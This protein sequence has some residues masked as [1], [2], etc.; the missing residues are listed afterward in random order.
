MRASQQTLLLIA[1]FEGFSPRPYRCPAGL[2]TIGYGHVIGAGEA[3][4]AISESQGIQWLRR[5]VAQA[6]MAVARLITVPLRQHQ[7]DALV[8]FTFNLGAGALQ[9]SA[10]RRVVNR[11]AHDE[12]PAQLLRWV[13]GGGKKLPGLVRRRAAEGRLYAS[14][15]NVF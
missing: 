11:H 4:D 2:L 3:I 9:R 6:E 5:D 15:S 14:F 13:Y 7:F 8:S 12:V 1:A 10:L